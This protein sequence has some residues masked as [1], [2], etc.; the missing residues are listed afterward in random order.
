MYNV[1]SRFYDYGTYN[2]A[3]VCVRDCVCGYMGGGV[4]SEIRMLTFA[5]GAAPRCHACS[6]T[7]PSTSCC[8][9][10]LA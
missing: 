2:T 1:W 4:C 5:A 7:Y 6:V 9:V 8:G 3:A 10:S